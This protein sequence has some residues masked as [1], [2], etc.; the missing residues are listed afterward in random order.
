M[1]QIVFVAAEEIKQFVTASLEHLALSFGYS[2]DNGDSDVTK[3]VTD[4]RTD[5]MSNI[6]MVATSEASNLFICIVSRFTG[7]NRQTL[8]ARH[9]APIFLAI[10]TA[11]QTTKTLNEMLDFMV[12]E[13]NTEN[14]NPDEQLGLNDYLNY[15]FQNILFELLLHISVN[16]ENM[17]GSI[18]KILGLQK[19]SAGWVTINSRKSMS[20][21]TKVLTHIHTAYGLIGL[22]IKFEATFKSN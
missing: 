4:H 7:T 12:H 16:R 20:V 18:V 21:E 5:I 3:F 22:I 10:C 14:G 13:G 6:M 8:I 19:D 1:G 11:N 15:D 2:H 9:I 17:I